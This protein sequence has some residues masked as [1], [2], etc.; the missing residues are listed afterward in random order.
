VQTKV[1]RSG[2]EC[3]VDV[4]LSVQYYAAYNNLKEGMHPGPAMQVLNVQLNGWKSTQGS[5]SNVV[6]L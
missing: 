6:T 3:D 2:A 1:L 5:Q 4:M